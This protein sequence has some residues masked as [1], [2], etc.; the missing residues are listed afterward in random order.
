MGK[1]HIYIGDGKGKTTAA[2]GFACRSSGAGLKVLFIQFMKD[3]SSSEIPQLAKLG[4]ECKGFG[5]RG[6]VSVPGPEDIALAQRGLAFVARELRNFDV[7]ILDEALTASTIGLITPGELIQFFGI[8]QDLVLTGRHAPKEM[9]DLADYVSEVRK[10]KH[11]FD[12][13]QKARRGVEF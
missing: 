8:P 11:P 1:T 6:F 2:V 5:R 13:G 7:V 12:H 4:V 10:V 3:A 9:I